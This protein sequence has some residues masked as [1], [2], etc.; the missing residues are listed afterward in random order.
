MSWRYSFGGE[1]EELG[2][3]SRIEIDIAPIAGGAAL[4]FTH[5]DL[6][7][8]ASRASHEQGWTGSL[9]KLVRRLGVVPA[10]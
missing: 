6:M 1:P 10:A 7:N 5:T 3:T 2:R 9:G 4:T 8:E